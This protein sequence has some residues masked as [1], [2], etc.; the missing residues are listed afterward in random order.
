MLTNK[1]NEKINVNGKINEKP[2]SSNCAKLA[3][4]MDVA[5]LKGKI[6]QSAY[7]PKRKTRGRGDYYDRAKP[8]AFC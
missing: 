7:V 5:I 1:I 4:L 2:N 6:R 8:G 3:H